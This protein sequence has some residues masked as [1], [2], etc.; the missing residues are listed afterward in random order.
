MRRA[1]LLAP[2]LLL[3]ACGQDPTVVQPAVFERPGATAF[4]CYDHLANEL[5]PLSTCDGLEGLDDEP[6]TLIAL[7]AQTARG[8]LAA[9]DLRED[10]VLD[11]DERVPGF[12][13]VRVGEGPSAVVVPE[14]RP[15]VTYVATFGSR[16]V[17]YYAT[18]RFLPRVVD[19]AIPNDGFV[20]LPEGPADLVL[21]PDGSTLIATLPRAGQLALIPVN[22]DGTLPDDPSAVTLLDLTAPADLEPL[23]QPELTTVYEKT[24]VPDDV[25]ADSLL[26]QPVDREAVSLGEAPT[27]SELVLDDTTLWV[28][29]S[30]LPVIHRF[31][32]SDG[33]APAELDA[34]LPGVPTDDIVLTPEVPELLEPAEFTGTARYL[35][36]LDATDGTVLAMDALEGSPTFGTVLP[37]HHGFG[38]SDRLRLAGAP[39][40]DLE[41]LTPGFPGDP[42]TEADRVSSESF[43]PDNLRGVFLAAG[44]T[45]GLVA[46]VDVHDLDALCRG[47]FVPESGAPCGDDQLNERD[48]VVLMRRH[49]VRTADFISEQ[50]F[51]RVA[52]TPRFSVDNNPGR[53]EGDGL[54]AIGSGPGLDGLLYEGEPG[55][56]PEYFPAL[57]RSGDGAP[58]ICAA[59]RP[60]D[61]RAQRWTATFEGAIPGT[62]RL[63]RLERDGSGAP[64]VQPDGSL[65]VLATGGDLCRVGVLG[66]ENT[67]LGAEGPERAYGGD[68]IVVTSEPPES[69]REQ[70]RCEAFFEN[71]LDEREFI[72]FPIRLAERDAVTL[73][74]SASSEALADLAACYPSLFTFE[75]RTRQAFTVLGAFSG[76]FHRVVAQADGVCVPDPEQP[77]D[78]LDASTHLLGRA[79]NETVYTNPLVSFSITRADIPDGSE[80][81]LEFTIS[82]PPPRQFADVG[83]RGRGRVGTI[84]ERLLYS[85]TDERLYVVDSNSSGFSQYDLF[86]LSR[87]RTFD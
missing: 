87:R 42:C 84:I 5:V 40:R 29:D 80:S 49:E 32:I 18:S 37:V 30:A 38:E 21:S 12:T 10:L 48:D 66:S 65:Q 22:A 25:R 36:A 20:T 27:P 56:G 67:Q 14:E 8:E 9:V 64:V 70:S 31:D 52:G 43:G 85:A 41:I 19:R 16:R 69:V 1:S 59:F 34:F 81:V 61:A 68:K 78:P 74:V 11:A 7:V 54:P 57:T 2:F 15:G 79:F 45:E 82:D 83:S 3:A 77:Y 24:C 35:Y 50:E 63:G 73:D 46:I 47:G 51:V 53:L 26:P 23:A 58:L 71:D 62:S 72:E 13:F 4:L 60:W 39:V 86:P 28:A 55:C 17:E 76:F 33:A 75:V 44:D 6:Y